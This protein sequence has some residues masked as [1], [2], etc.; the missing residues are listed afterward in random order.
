MARAVKPHQHL[1]ARTIPWHGLHLEAHERFGIEHFR[2]GQREVL[3]AI[4]SGRDVLAL[5]PTGAGKSLCYQLPALFL[6][7]PVVVVSPLLAL[8]RDQQQKA[9]DAK[10]A[11]E[12]LDSTQKVGETSE[13]EELIE[14]GIPQLLYVTPERLENSEFLSMLAQTGVSLLAIDEAHCISEWGHD[15]RPA[16]L[17]LRYVRERLGNPPVLAVTATATERVIEDILRELKA[18][19]AVVVNEGTERDNLEWSVHHTVNSTTKQ[20]HLLDLISHE[21]GKGI[22]YTASIRSANEVYLWLSARGIC[23]ERYHGKLPRRERER[24]QTEFMAGKIKA[25]VATKAFGLGIDKPDIRFVYHYEFPDSLETYYQEAGRAGRDGRPARA[26]LLYRL[27]DRRIQRYFLRGKYPNAAEIRSVLNAMPAANGSAVQLLTAASIAERAGLPRR[28]TKVV[29]HLLRG[30]G[31]VRR[32]MRGYRVQAGRELADEELDRLLASYAER[33]RNDLDRLDEMMRYAESTRCRKQILRSYF[34][35]PEGEPCGVCDNC[36]APEPG[37][38]DLRSPPEAVS[39]RSASGEFQ[40]TAPETLPRPEAPAFH[41]GER[42][43]HKR[44]GVG[45]V[46]DEDSGKI[47]ARFEKAGERKVRATYVKRAA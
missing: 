30:T 25:L 5:M 4:F 46:L 11:V 27:E 2:P 6:P 31:L 15:F 37:R 23:A 13:I 21:Q 42:I 47:L 17:S 39:V 26:V 43:R 10:I 22:V 14:A 8:M 32:G 12:K 33:A 20:L 38:G 34:G 19:D 9:D 3:E 18:P 28:R 16:Y 35:E 1:R 29:L 41:I 44:F 40:T 45:T 36:R 24:V 7:K